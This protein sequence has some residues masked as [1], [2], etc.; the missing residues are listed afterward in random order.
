MK[1]KFL[2]D[3]PVPVAA[4]V[5]IVQTGISIKYT[6]ESQEEKREKRKKEKCTGVRIYKL[7]IG[8]EGETAR[9]EI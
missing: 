4:V 6:S 2:P 9:S 8:R 3:E 7:V 5:L 1:C